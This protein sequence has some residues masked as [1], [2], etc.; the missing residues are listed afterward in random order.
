M[1][2][3]I[4]SSPITVAHDTESTNAR[5]APAGSDTKNHR[6]LSTHFSPLAR[7]GIVSLP[8]V[9][10]IAGELVIV[11]SPFDPL[12]TK[13]SDDRKRVIPGAMRLIA[14]PDTIWSTPKV[15]VARAWSRPP[16][17]PPNAPPTSVAHGPQCHPAK[18]AVQ[19]P[20]IIMPS[21]PMLATPARSEYKPPSPANRIGD[22]AAIVAMKVPPVVRSSAPVSTHVKASPR[23]PM[24]A[25]IRPRC[26]GLT[27]L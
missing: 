7:P 15:I 11:P 5:S 25:M 19:V 14:T 4:I 16:S 12:P 21:R 1:V 17:M 8:I 13:T 20:R 24:T 9:C 26:H 23:N 27:A 10:W 3:G 6:C 22:A 18:A 2:N